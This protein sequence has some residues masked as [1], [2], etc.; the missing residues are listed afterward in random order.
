[1]SLKRN[2]VRLLTSRK[3]FYP[4]LILAVVAANVNAVIEPAYAQAEYM[5]SRRQSVVEQY[6][7]WDTMEYKS[8]VNSIHAALLKTGKVLLIAGSGNDVKQFD[9]GTFRTVVWNPADGSFKEIPTPWDV[10]CAGHAFLPDGRLL[11]AGG[12]KN[13][14]N[15][16]MTPRLNYGGLKDSYV[17]DPDTESY[18][19]VDKMEVARWYPTLVGLDDGKVLAAA[20]LDDRGRMSQGQTEIYDPATK[21][22]TLSQTLKHVFPTYPSLTLMNDGR[23]FYSG[24]NQGYVPGAASLEPGI[25]NLKNNN[26]QKVNGLPD[27]IRTDN[28]ATVLLPP[29]Q[30]QKVMI[31]G[32]ARAGD[33]PETET[34]NRTAIIDLD[35]S[36]NP[37]YV[38]GPNLKNATRYPSAVILPDDTVFQTGGSRGYRGAGGDLHSAQ[39]YNPATNSF[40]DAASPLVGRNYHSEA[41]LLPDGRVATFG[42]DPLFGKFEMRIEIYSP[43]YLFRG[44]RPVI[45][46]GDTE[47]VR[48]TK[49]GFSLPA[50][51]NVKNVK[52]VRPSSVTHVTDVEQRSVDLTYDRTASGVDVDIPANNGLLPTGWYMAYV[53]NDKNIPSVAHWVH[54]Q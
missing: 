18:E 48:G 44:E 27:P 50:G 31:M 36:D 42:S 22:W 43:S 35:S 13:Y 15:L 25:W 37:S 21:Q 17:F 12:T 5:L 14:E 32:G 11:I 29:A 20:G 19:K 4:I 7:R 9:A 34:T 38:Q 16:D 10:F 23:L 47:L 51:T 49:A 46:S 45:S 3:V 39:I 1:M 6:G 24:G 8:P 41:I 33:S 2:A 54:V 28:S 30:D 52:L 53:T 40:T 26:F